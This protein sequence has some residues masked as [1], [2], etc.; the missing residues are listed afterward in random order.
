ML[1]FWK[2]SVACPFV[3][4]PWKGYFA[5]TSVAMSHEMAVTT[6]WRRQN[7]LWGWGRTDFPEATSNLAEPH[8]NL[9]TLFHLWISSFLSGAG[10]QFSSQTTTVEVAGG[11]GADAS[12]YHWWKTPFVWFVMCLLPNLLFLLL[13]CSLICYLPAWWENYPPHLVIV[14][15]SSPVCLW[16]DSQ[17]GGC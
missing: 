7:F 10:D 11:E 13:F 12:T 1:G 15:C 6:F 16:N 8:G 17:T 2:G 9:C 5:K 14:L 4:L 3:P